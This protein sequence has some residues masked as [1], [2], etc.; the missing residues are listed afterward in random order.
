MK[1]AKYILDTIATT[2]FTTIAASGSISVEDA[3]TYRLLSIKEDGFNIVAVDGDLFDGK[4]VCDNTYDTIVAYNNT[5]L[6]KNP[7][8]LFDFNNGEIPQSSQYVVEALIGDFY[9]KACENMLSSKSLEDLTQKLPQIKKDVNFLKDV[10][11][12]AG[13]E[14]DVQVVRQLIDTYLTNNLTTDCGY[15]ENTQSKTIFSYA[16]NDCEYRVVGLHL[17]KNVAVNV[18]DYI[19]NCCDDAIAKLTVTEGISNDE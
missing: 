8:T 2:I 14:H 18:A 11:V 3:D 15:V 7:Q 19:S 16:L 5:G 4:S 12:D 9:V 6:I 13:N 1:I 10:I 17:V